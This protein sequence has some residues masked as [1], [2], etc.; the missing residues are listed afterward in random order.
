MAAVNSLEW[1][2]PFRGLASAAETA[3]AAAALNPDENFDNATAWDD[4]E[5]RTKK[6]KKT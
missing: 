2:F 6:K 1:A 4:P 5:Q 3:S